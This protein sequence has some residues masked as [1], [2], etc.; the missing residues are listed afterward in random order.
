[1]HKHELMYKAE[2]DYAIWKSTIQ[3]FTNYTHTHTHLQ[4]IHAVSMAQSGQ[5][6]P[7]ATH[8]KCF[9]MKIPVC[10]CTISSTSLGT[11]PSNSKMNSADV[12]SPWYKQM[13]WIIRISQIFTS[14]RCIQIVPKV[15]FKCRLRVLP[16]AMQ[17]K[18]FLSVFLWFL[19][20]PVFKL[21]IYR[22]ERVPS[23]FIHCVYILV[24]ELA[25]RCECGPTV[26][27]ICVHFFFSLFFSLRLCDKVHNVE[28]F[29]HK[30][31]SQLAYKCLIKSQKVF[32]KCCGRTDK[33]DFAL[34]VHLWS[35]CVGA[36]IFQ[37][38]RWVWWEFIW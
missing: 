33:S 13:V 4:Y 36:G 19:L 10:C 21:R 31:L 32:H 23:T 7:Y 35:N 3:M 20:S 17:I 34:L 8:T 25:I 30:L 5:H 18:K 27:R 11:E 37:P 14:N 15:E 1:M 29:H 28:A 9:T 16:F 38:L 22:F 12:N 6:S 24:F 26:E 2:N